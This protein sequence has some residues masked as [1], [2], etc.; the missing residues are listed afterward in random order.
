LPLLPG[1]VD[2]DA[3]RAE[4]ADRIDPGFAKT[5]DQTAEDLCVDAARTVGRGQRECR[6]PVE[7]GIGRHE[8][9]FGDDVSELAAPVIGEG[10]PQID[11]LR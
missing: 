3:C 4:K 10:Y 11:R 1:Q 5:F 7:E 9:S 2:V 8:V 6:Q